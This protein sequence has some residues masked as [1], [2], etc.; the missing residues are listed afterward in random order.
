MQSYHDNATE[1]KEETLEQ[2]IHD[3]CQEMSG[4]TVEDEVVARKIS[5]ALKQLHLAMQPT[6]A[7]RYSKDLVV[8]ASIW[9]VTASKPVQ[10]YLASS[11]FNSSMHVKAA[12]AL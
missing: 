12:A 10:S 2:V 7:R 1:H 8:L 5:F 3:F 9:K 11:C 4:L 6:Q